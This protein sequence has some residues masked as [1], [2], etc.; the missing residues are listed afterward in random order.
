MSPFASVIA[1][2]H[3]AV[4][5]RN[6]EIRVVPI[7]K[8]CL[9]PV[10]VR[11]CREALKICRNLQTFKCTVA[12]VVAVLLPSL[13]QKIRLEDVTLYA[14]LTTDQAA[15]L[16]K[17]E[18]LESLTIEFAS[19]NVVDMLPTW[20]GSL[21][22]TLTSLTLYTIHELHEDVLK[23]ILTNLPNLRGLHV[24][25]CLKVDHTV[26]FRQIVHTPL[27]EMLSLT[28]SENTAPLIFPSPPMRHLKH[29]AFDTRYSMQPS[30]SPSILASILAHIRLSAPPLQSFTIKLPERKIVVGDPFITQLVEH[31]GSTL[32]RLSFLDC[33]VSQESI[34]EICK[35]CVNLQR[36]DVSI[37]MKELLPFTRNLS[38]SKT[39]H[40]IVDVD[41]HVDHGM[42]PTL[43][44][45]NVR[46]MMSLSSS[47]RKVVS[48]HRIWTG[49]LDPVQGVVVTLEKRRSH[50]Y[51]SLW[52]MIR[53]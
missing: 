50:S 14:N 8:S 4:H 45:E 12:N 40:T 38:F 41:N 3:L 5:V 21:T 7:V 30:P 10:F 22:K 34:A 1:H 9:H 46:Y 2:P 33:G 16:N 29:L 37:P 52:F 44:Q 43:K 20:T 48:N 31:Y 32:R 18:K 42:R 53:D 28:T 36:L 6:I 19:W 35:N 24:V 49:R 23:S 25:G 51:G 17:L 15:M 27:L 26:I 47:L 39:L 13:A 11:E